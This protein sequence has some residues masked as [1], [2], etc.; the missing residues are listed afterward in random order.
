MTPS[1]FVTYW[2]WLPTLL[3]LVGLAFMFWPES[4]SGGVERFGRTLIGL[5][6]LISAVSSCA[7]GVLIT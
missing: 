6:F 3:A 2:W 1:V 7:T 4:N 5:V